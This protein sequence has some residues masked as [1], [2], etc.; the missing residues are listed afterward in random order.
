MAMFAPLVRTTQPAF[1]YPGEVVNFY[2]SLSSYHDIEEIAGAKI[3][4]INPNQSAAASNYLIYEG[5]FEKNSWNVD[6][7]TKEKYISFILGEDKGLVKNNFYQAQLYFYT[8]ENKLSEPSQV[9]LI[10]P[11]PAIDND[12]VTISIDVENQKVSGFFSYED[13]ST[14]ETIQSYIVTILE[15]SGVEYT[16]KAIDNTNLGLSFSSKIDYY[17][18][19]G[20]NYI[21][22]INYTTVNGY[23]NTIQ[24]DFISPTLEADEEWEDFTAL[25]SDDN[26]GGSIHIEITSSLNKIGTL[27]IQRTS[28]ES[29]FRGWKTVATLKLEDYLSQGYTISWYDYM[30][31]GGK[32]YKYRFRYL[33]NGVSYLSDNNYYYSLNFSDVFLSAPDKQLALRY[34]TKIDNFKWVTVESVTNTLGGIYP[35]VRRSAAT[36]YRQFNLSGLI[37]FDAFETDSLAVD[38]QGKSIDFW[39]D[40]ESSSLF[41]S[42]EDAYAF[43]NTVNTHYKNYLQNPNIYEK[44][45]KDLALEFLTD[46]KPKLFRSFQEGNI[47][48]YLSNISFSPNNQ[49]NRRVY[50]FSATVTEICEASPENLKKYALDKHIKAYRYILR[51]RKE[52]LT[53]EATHDIFT[54]YI[55]INQLFNNNALILEYEEL[56]GV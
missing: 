25:F 1:V 50:S 24:K 8:S 20:S 53:S 28:E 46:G 3:R 31:E 10:R 54:P 36:K 13:G 2:F 7:T 22:K 29:D 43:Q 4:I 9:S 17:F 34:D 49:L 41:L 47:I 6:E 44:K 19:E 30:A 37:Y 40:A 26:F 45:F 33:T 48:V 11:I 18:K 15:D 56:E 5:T 42:Q 32:L 27:L 21:I 51:V 55:N 39:L 14:I 38:S 23:E 16:S 35:L 12:T 52:T